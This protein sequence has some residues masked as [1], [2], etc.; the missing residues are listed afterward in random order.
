MLPVRI[1]EGLNVAICC[2]LCVHI[3]F[4]YEYII[5]IYKEKVIIIFCRSLSLS[6][7]CMMVTLKSTF[8]DIEWF[9]YGPAHCVHIRILLAVAA[10]ARRRRIYSFSVVHYLYV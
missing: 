4:T 7:T 1:C 2:A 9:C 8:N 10:A 6:L 3:A 5:C